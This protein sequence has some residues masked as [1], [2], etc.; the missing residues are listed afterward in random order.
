MYR[1]RHADPPPS[2]IDNIESAAA[3][4]LVPRRRRALTVTEAVDTTTV[5]A[6]ATSVAATVGAVVWWRR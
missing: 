6:G 3:K 2:M 4:G 1:S 5:L